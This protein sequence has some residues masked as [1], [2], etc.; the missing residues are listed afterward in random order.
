MEKIQKILYEI[1][2]RGLYPDVKVVESAPYPE[3]IIDGR[4]ILMFG[5]YNYLG[6]SVRPEVKE[7]AIV[8]IEK[9]GIGSGGSRLI[10]GTYDIHIQLEEEL[11]KFKRE[12]LAMVLPSGFGTNVGVI[13]AVM[14]LF[15][16]NKKQF[17]RKQ[18]I[19]SDELNHASIIDGCKL[20]DAKVVVY[21]HKDMY[22]LE[23]QLHKYKKNRKLIVTDTVFSMDGD[24]A[25][26]AKILALAKEYGAMVMVDDAHAT[27]ILGNHG[28]GGSDFFDLE[29]Q[30]DINMSTS[31]TFGAVGGF[32]AG[33]KNIIEYL[34]VACRTY[35]FATSMPPLI[36][37][38]IL[39]ALQIIQA[40]PM[41]REQIK[42]NAE[43]LRTNL[44]KLGFDTLG[45]ETPI[46]PILLG[47]DEKAVHAQALFFEKGIFA[48]TV[49]WP[50]VV[51]GQSRVRFVLMSSHTKEQIDRLL[52]V[53]ES[54][55]KKLN[56][57]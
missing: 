27:G 29:G 42:N 2:K 15:G 14:N 18:I 37:S 50:A 47:S 25:P 52:T 46:I 51:K 9:Y 13:S 49:R 4:K 19:L 20:S 55:G 31:K 5:S 24:I 41:L 26:L 16:I 30:I 17:L 7:A 57:I 48:P 11:A 8:A 53:T 28:G 10:S 35:M 3:V 36:A 33:G 40:E 1:K 45:S 12:E 38:A 22:D 34:R 6:L 54:I 32:V 56:L 44:Q 21:R 43:Y 23:A 39:V